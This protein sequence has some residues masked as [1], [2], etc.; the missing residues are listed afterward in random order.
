MVVEKREKETKYIKTLS[1]N[2]I[3]ISQAEIKCKNPTF[4][5]KNVV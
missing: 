5:I 2:Y 4:S 3:F 1:I